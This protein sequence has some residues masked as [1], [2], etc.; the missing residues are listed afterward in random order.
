MSLV[1]GFELLSTLDSYCLNFRNSVKNTQVASEAGDTS[2]IVKSSLEFTK[3][4][5]DGTSSALSYLKKGVAF[6]PFSVDPRLLQFTNGAALSTV[7]SGLGLV[8]GSIGLIVEVLAVVR[9]EE[10]IDSLSDLPTPP[11]IGG[12][13]KELTSSEIDKLE[14]AVHQLEKLNFNKFLKSL[15][16]YLKAK[17]E[18]E[19]GK[20]IFN[21]MREQINR[22]KDYYDSAEAEQITDP[23]KTLDA[24]RLAEEIQRGALKKQCF[25]LLN[26]AACVF[27]IAASIALIVGCPFAGLIIFTVVGLALAAT[28]YMLK[29]GWVENPDEGFNWKLC[30]PGFLRYKIDP[31]MADPNRYASPTMEAFN[32]DAALNRMIQ[33]EAEVEKPSQT[34][35]LPTSFWRN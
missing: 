4:S 11:V 24:L 1:R 15:P 26:V 33:G 22:G 19:H 8:S 9:Q 31:M 14:K 20:D 29:S 18:K 13:T 12:L 6:V 25:H 23:V 34:G 5:I 16:E 28:A 27:G 32:F 3:G 2:G 17:I 35:P 10:T 7:L 30:I 21:S